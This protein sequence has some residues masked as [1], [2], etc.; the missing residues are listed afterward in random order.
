MKKIIKAAIILGVLLI[1]ISFGARAGGE[2]IYLVRENAEG[3]SLSIQHGGSETPLE[4]NASLA[5]IF[6]S[7]SDLGGGEIYLNGIEIRESIELSGDITLCGSLKVK[8]SGIINIA[9]G[10]ILFSNLSLEMTGG[11]VRIKNGS[12]ALEGVDVSSAGTAFLLNHT[13]SAS[14]IIKS[15]RIVGEGEMPVILNEV[16]TLRISGGEIESAKGI[17]I[18]NSASLFLLGDG[19]I[20]GREYGVSTNKPLYLSYGDGEFNGALSLKYNRVFQ[21]GS[22]TPVLYGASEDSI[23]NVKLYDN[24]GVE[25]S[26]KHFMAHEAVDEKS[27]GAVYLP[28]TVR[29]YYKD[30]CI[31]TDEVLSGERANSY[32]APERIGYSFSFWSVDKAGVVSYDFETSVNNSLDLYAIYKLRAPSFFLSSLEFTY[33]EEGGVIE[34]SDISHPLLSEST[35]YYEWY[36]NG[37]P[38]GDGSRALRLISV[39]DSGSYSLKITLNHE[40]NSVSVTTPAVAVKIYKKVID[41]P[42]VPPAYYSGDTIFAEL[43]STSVYEVEKTQG[44]DAGTYP[45]KL[46]ILDK[47]NYCFSGGEDTAYADFIILP[48][49]NYW[50]EEPRI[51]DYYEGESP[52]PSAK[53]RFGTVA[54]LYS[55]KIDGEYGTIPPDKSGVFYC[56]A[57][58]EES[59]NYSALQSEPVKVEVFSEIAV[60]MSILNPPYRS[61]YNSFDC[62]DADGLLVSVTFNSGRR[63]TVPSDKLTITYG[64]ADSLRSADTFVV[65]SYLGVS[66]PIPVNVSRLEYDISGIKFEDI[67]LIYD[68]KSK[69]INYRGELPSGLDGIP[70]KA[71]IIGGGKTVGS[72]TVVLCFE[73]DSAEYNLPEAIEATLTVAPFESTVIFEGCEQV[74]DGSFKIPVAYFYDVD[75]IKTY[76]EVIGGRS[77]AGDYTVVART[78]DSNYR[79][80]S[81]SAVFKILKA[82][83]DLSEVT[84]SEGPFVYDGCEKSVELRGLPSGVSVIGYVD[85]KGITAGQY[86]A[87][88][89]LSYD[90]NN[91]NPPP[92][93]SCSWEIEKGSYDLSGFYFADAQHIYDG[94]LHYPS[95]IG[96]VP[97]GADGIPLRYAFAAGVKNVIEGKSMVEIV[98]STE[99]KNYNAPAPVCAFVQILPK[100]ISA[101]WSDTSLV[102]NTLPQ[103]PLAFAQECDILVEGAVTDAGEY[104]ATAHS[105]DPNFILTNPECSFVIGKAE[106]YWIESITISSVFEGRELK[107][108]AICASGEVSYIYL[109]E[110]GKVCEAPSA[111]G[112]YKVKAV[113]EGDN[114]YKP[115]ETE[116][117]SFEI[118]A[119]VPIGIEYELLREEFFAFEELNAEDI[120]FFISYNDGSRIE[121]EINEVKIDY[122]QNGSLR[123]G[124][125]KVIASYLDLKVPVTLSVKRADYDTS[126]VRWSDGVF[127][128]D[129]EKKGIELIGLPSG[130]TVTEYHG[131]GGISAGKYSVTAVLDYDEVNYNQP[132][133]P[134]GEYI[135]K[136]SR[137]PVPTVPDIVYNGKAQAPSVPISELYNIGKSVGMA[138]GAY[139]VRLTLVDA[140]NYEFASGESDIFV[141]Y[142]IL[143]RKLSIKISDSE[144]FLFE[145]ASEPTFE[146]VE[147]E[148]IDGDEITVSYYFDG[149]A[150]RAKVVLPNYEVE[151]IEGRLTQHSKL[152]ERGKLVLFVII[153]LI[154][155]MLLI[156]WVLFMRKGRIAR[157]V[158]VVKCRISPVSRVSEIEDGGAILLPEPTD[159]LEIMSVDKERADGLI[160]DDLARDLVNNQ[161]VEIETSGNKKRIVNVDTLSSSFESG[162]IIDVNRLKE[163]SLVPYD[164]AY[165]KVLARGMIDK[166]L[167]VYANDF[168]LSAVKMIAL[169][170]GEAIRVVTVRTKKNKSEKIENNDKNDQNT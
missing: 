158:S 67:T 96:E 145:K 131:L 84:W 144:R 134:S 72:Y 18:D 23:K 137:V 77:L 48:S 113:T 156:L 12:L 90:E 111:P 44:I 79:L 105:L 78:D 73:S 117:C 29:Y 94:E 141:E 143:P 163:M 130:V 161:R 123:Y 63:E 88:A 101:V 28:H 119:V 169:T 168:S 27:F 166:P 102:Y 110:D 147:G 66:T 112:K 132:I 5:S 36:K 19:R 167:K 162:E 92:E 136:K 16:G 129:G 157:W 45:V 47:E 106:N 21:S 151:V 128:Y 127:V 118:I 69:S 95:V 148:L 139:K 41:L 2:E 133:I 138:V 35:L 153:L 160:S 55:D 80:V 109:T 93:Q 146:I 159:S 140:L 7:I 70:L 71:R 86:L 50:I 87:K 74:Y 10:N 142:V 37:A 64:S 25:Y 135:I 40:N 31:Y 8:N 76:L 85:N 107:P 97:C 9:S 124:I 115:S 61:D 54:F 164:T 38:I 57:R 120:L 6:A 59:E 20:E 1:F 46:E 150:V 3:Y 170:G 42:S 26:V 83:Y 60:G 149:E 56:I 52:S 81:S 11:Q 99:S 154:F 165:I 122:G 121:A 89:L 43:Y 30:A 34:P 125:Q 24:D 14:L 155:T 116:T 75:G 98:F 68:G 65:A 4:S 114:N 17:A 22:I 39:S 126:G 62:F 15:G 58:V 82:D 108:S 91:Y 13:A 49:C 32:D 103:K 33:S 100:E 51:F 104:I 152:S 53:A